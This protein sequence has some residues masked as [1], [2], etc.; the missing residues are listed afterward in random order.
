MLPIIKH[1]PCPDVSHWKRPINFPALDPK[2]WLMF[3]KATESDNILDVMFYEWWKEIRRHGM[4]RGGFHFLRPGDIGNQADFFVEVI[5]NAGYDND[6]IIVL[7]VEDGENELRDV[8]QWLEHV[9]RETGKRPIIYSSAIIINVMLLGFAPPAWFNDYYWWLAGYPF[10]PDKYDEIWSDYIPRGVRRENVCAWQYSEKGRWPG[11]TGNV[12]LNLLSPW[13]IDEINLLP[14]IQGEPMPTFIYSFTPA[15]SAGSQ[16]RK[17][18][19]VLS[20][21]S[22]NAIPFGT[23]AYGD[24]KWIA[25]ADGDSVKKGDTWLEIKK[26]DGAVIG[27]VAEIHLGVRY[28]TV[29]EINPPGDPDPTPEPNPDTNRLEVNVQYIGGKLIGSV[30]GNAQ[31]IDFFH[32]FK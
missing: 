23:F 18:H 13:W 24:V 25:P 15:K 20:D 26:D 3:T 2:P 32:E 7:D 1:P 14:P 27:W 29:N 30:S 28:G 11:I 4:R 12:D 17:D 9:E 16:V 19:T 8:I 21:K 22:A 6:D 10:E 5:S 31:G